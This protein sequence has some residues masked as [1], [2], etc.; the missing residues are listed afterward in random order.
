MAPDGHW[1]ERRLVPRM[2]AILEAI[3]WG[4]SMLHALLQFLVSSPWP[5]SSAA[6]RGAVDD[7]E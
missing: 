4:L 5:A 2:C 1:N 6:P 3:A 7:E